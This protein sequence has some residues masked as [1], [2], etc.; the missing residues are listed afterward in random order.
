MFPAFAFLCV[1]LKMTFFQ[2]LMADYLNELLVLLS[3][4]VLCYYVEVYLV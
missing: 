2:K 3:F 1:W 4:Y